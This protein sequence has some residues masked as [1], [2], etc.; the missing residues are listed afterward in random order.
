MSSMDKEGCGF[1]AGDDGN[2]FIVVHREVLLNCD[3]LSRGEKVEYE[4]EFDH[5]RGQ[6]VC[7]TCSVL[8]AHE[9]LQLRVDEMKAEFAA[10]ATRE[11][12]IAKQEHAVAYAETLKRLRD[13][14]LRPPYDRA[15]W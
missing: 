1:I 7:S 10:R 9:D 5:K 4:A 3:Y 15:K 2:K 12:A 11:R 6:I 14:R 13:F 8:F